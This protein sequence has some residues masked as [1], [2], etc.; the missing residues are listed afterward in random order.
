MYYNRESEAQ[1]DSSGQ[2]LWPEWMTSE[3]TP[4]GGSRMKGRPQR[5]QKD[6]IEKA[7][8]VNSGE[9]PRIKPA[10]I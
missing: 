8:V 7:E 10:I 3:G 9:W 1:E 4:Q 6:E 2:D 5:R